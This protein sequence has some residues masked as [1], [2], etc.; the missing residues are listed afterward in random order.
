MKKPM[1]VYV[2]ILS[3]MFVNCKNDDINSQ[4][5]NDCIKA[6]KIATACPSNGYFQVLEN[7]ITGESWTYDKKT[8]SN[9]ISVSNFIDSLKT[10]TLYLTIDYSKNWQS[11]QLQRPCTTLI[12][13]TPPSGALYCLKNISKK[14]CSSTNEN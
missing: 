12:N 13:F 8:Y 14:K 6:Y 1:I 9:V 4:S 11:C 2:L 10:D 7:T 5:K 3:V